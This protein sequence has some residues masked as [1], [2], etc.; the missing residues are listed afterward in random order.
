MSEPSHGAY[1]AVVGLGSALGAAARLA[2]GAAAVAALGPGFPW[3][4]LAVN[5]LGSFAIGLYA[6]LIAPGGPIDPRPLTRAFVVAG[7]CGGFTTFSLFSLETASLWAQGDRAAAAANVLGSVA[8]WLVAAAAGH[9][10]GARAYQDSD[11]TR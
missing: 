7:L 1:L 10:L 4:T 6:A 8:V 9:H 11:A 5:A 3:G 2:V